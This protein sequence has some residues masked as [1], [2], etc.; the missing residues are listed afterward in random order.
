MHNWRIKAAA[1]AAVPVLAVTVAACGE[2]TGGGEGGLEGTIKVDGSS[3]VGPLT[4]AASELFREDNG[5]VNVGVATSGTGGGFE[6]F[7]KGETDISDAS[8]PIK[9][10]EIAL[11]KEGKVEYTELQV[12][13]D[14]LT[15]LVHPDNPVKC[16][17]IEQLNQIWGPKSKV[18]SWSE[19]KD[20]DAKFDEKLTLYGPGTDSGTFEYFADEVNGDK[21][22]QRADYEDIGEDDNTGIQGVAESKGGMFYVG[23]EYYAQNQD[24]VKALEIDGGDGCV[25]PTPENVQ[26]G[27]YT[28]LGR[29]LFIYPSKK[30]MESEHIKAFVDYYIENA[31][32][33][34][35]EAGFIEMTED[36]AAKSAETLAS[37][38]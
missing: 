28:P 22:A 21:E 29:P 19:V 4:E 31:A 11:C 5:G 27:K 7:C 14:A 37:A 33:I 23:Y 8:R 30:A 18:K 34:A 10:E 35:K 36:Q 3:T 6:K 16:V 12:A 2:Q 15:V 38:G 25:A 20:L 9:D 32:T 1:L 24:K 13:N 26:T 17:T